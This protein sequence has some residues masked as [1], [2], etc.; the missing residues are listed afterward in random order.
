MSGCQGDNV[1]TLTELFTRADRRTF[2]PGRRYDLRTFYPGGSPNFFTRADR[3]T[4]L[5]GRRYDLRT[6]WVS[7]TFLVRFLARRTFWYGFWLG[8]LFGTVFGSENFL[9]RFLAG[10]TKSREARPARLSST[11]SGF[12]TTEPRRL[13]LRG[14]CTSGANRLKANR[15]LR[16]GGY[17]QSH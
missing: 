16:G 12:C 4:F 11:K 17:V 7:R 5:P 10:S 1:D 2:L 14:F 6:F 9:V 13:S 8:E 3:Q 15:L